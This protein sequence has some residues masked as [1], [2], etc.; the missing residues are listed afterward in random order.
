VEIAAEDR[1]ALL[2]RFGLFGIRLASALLRG[3]ISDPTVL[4]HELARRSGLD[5]LLRL[6]S[7]QFQERATHL[8]ARTALSAVEALLR[9]RPRTGAERLS[10]SLERIQASAHEFRELR[11]LATLHTEGLALAAD[12]A[13]TSNGW[14]A[15]MASP[16]R[17]GWGW[18]TR[19]PSRS[20]GTGPWRSCAAGARWLKTP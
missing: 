13:A 15:G 12:L 11:L 6:I 18:R 17:S 2:D 5:Q 3:G 10:A 14:S 16:L 19:R 1:A 20:F 8:K 7:R 9:E 4:A